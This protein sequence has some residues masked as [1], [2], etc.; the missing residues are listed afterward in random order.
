MVARALHF[1][2]T[3]PNLVRQDFTYTGSTFVNEHQHHN[4]S[5]ETDEDRQACVDL[6]TPFALC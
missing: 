4:C 2:C 5:Q 1:S 3:F 6:Q